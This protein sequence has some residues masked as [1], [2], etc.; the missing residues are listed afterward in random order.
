MAYIGLWIFLLPLFAYCGQFLLGK[1]LP[2][3]GDWLG[4]LAIL[5]SLCLSSVLFFRVLTSEA[6]LE[7]VAYPWFTLPA[8][9]PITFNV[10]IRVDNYSAVLVFMVSLC[11]FLIQFFATGYMKGEERYDRFFSYL[12][13][14]TASMLGLVLSNNLLLF[15]IFWELMGVCSYLLIGFYRERPPAGKAALRAFLTTRV[16]DTGLFLGLC[17]IIALFGSSEWSTI[18]DKVAQ[19]TN[20][21]IL[22]LPALTVIAAL[23]LMGT[24]GKSA[25]VP[26]H[27]WLPGA[28]EGPTPVSALIHAATMVAAGVFLL[29]RAF[30]LLAAA[31]E[32]LLLT[33]YLG[34]FTAL[35]AGLM[36]AGQSELKKVLAY[37]T[38]S[39]L[40]LMVLAVGVGAI[41]AAF[42]HLLTHA[43]FKA[44]LFLGAGSVY[45]AAHTQK[46]SE[47]GGLKKEMPWT[48]RAMLISTLALSGLPFFSGYVSKDRILASVL[49]HCL[50]SR[51]DWLLVFFGFGAAALTAFYMFRL[52]YLTFFG[53]RQHID[54]DH[55]VHEQPWNMTLPVGILAVF[56]FAIWFAGFSGIEAFDSIF[57]VHW[58]EKV[59][60]GVPKE[61]L[62]TLS[63]SH[64]PEETLSFAHELTSI[65]TL[66][67]SA[68]SILAASFLYLRKREVEQ[69]AEQIVHKIAWL[70]QV[71]VE[72]VWVQSVQRVVFFAK[73]FAARFD[74]LIIDDGMVTGTSQIVG[75]GGRWLRRLQDGLVQHYLLFALALLGL[76][77]LAFE[78]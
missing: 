72:R 62:A 29:I 26:L 61:A 18:Y 44:C 56:C 37:S 3:K 73:D 77:F 48:F 52:L 71:G 40:G 38:I 20:A 51:S 14:F 22:G 25:Q 68:C 9:N 13:L 60:E 5:G 8:S 55:T 30:P 2:R 24:V 63:T 57:P 6:I 41:P 33:A 36:A 76:F 58:F 19:A 46:L 69:K 35:F 21:Q 28:M 12:S 67:F 59:M 74:N 47:L 78:I 66:L 50:D 16:G 31:P 27:V 43:F 54:P 1:Y 15:F 34:G 32:I 42:L 10:G 45:H 75:A 53:T 49:A 7:D 70:D 17:A 39:Q 65:L 64:P 23:V 11:S 4:I